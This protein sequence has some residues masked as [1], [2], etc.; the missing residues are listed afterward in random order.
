MLG[1]EVRGLWCFEV[2]EGCLV[3]RRVV[4]E[5]HWW[6]GCLWCLGRWQ[7]AELRG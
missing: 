7:E 4:A 5:L 3:E 6:V 1:W 2:V